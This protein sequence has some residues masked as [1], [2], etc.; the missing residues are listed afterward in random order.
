MYR[1]VDI[2]DVEMLQA[3]IEEAGFD[4]YNYTG[5]G[6]EKSCVAFT[7][8]AEKSERSAIADMVDSCH[9]DIERTDILSHALRG[10]L[11]D[12]MGKG[13]VLYFPNYSE[14]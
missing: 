13:T 14:E 2:E 5:R 3:I 7:V 4:H 8:E 9:G 1:I 10:S 6:S 11:V 12:G